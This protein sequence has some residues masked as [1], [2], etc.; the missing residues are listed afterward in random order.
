MPSTNRPITANNRYRPASRLRRCVMPRRVRR[1]AGHGECAVGAGAAAA[2]V[3][4]R[5]PVR[6]LFEA[7]VASAKDP[8]YTVV[9]PR[10]RLDGAST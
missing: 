8:K 10:R 1:R 7:G 2:F 9:P 5:H 4:V 3:A 6:D